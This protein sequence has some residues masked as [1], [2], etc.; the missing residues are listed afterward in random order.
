MKQTWAVLAAGAVLGSTLL[1]GCMERQGDLGNRNIRENSVRYDMLGN[2]VKVPRFDKDQMNVVNRMHGDRL[3]TNSL[4]G[5][6]QNYHLSMNGEI[7]QK[8]S[9]MKEVGKA[10]V[11]LT[12]NNAYVAITTNLTANQNNLKNNSTNHLRS[13]SRINGSYLPKGAAIPRGYQTQSLQDTGRFDST[14]SYDE[15]KPSTGRAMTPRH[16]AQYAPFAK[17][18]PHQSH[19]SHQLAAEPHISA[20]IKERI[21]EE[22]RKM[23][24]HIKQVYVSADPDFVS[25]MAS[26]WEDAKKGHP[27]QG[28]IVEFNALVE[29]VFP[30]KN[31]AM[32]TE[33]H[34]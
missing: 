19:Q 27:I 12:D 34:Q 20:A 5:L 3:H 24:P 17:I 6:H 18:D 22:V 4:V 30:A 31:G 15:L 2:Q 26:Y 21:T 14:K 25:R 11:M 28:F 32:N 33:N 1:T 16:E 8:L 7:A 10:F 13:L 9:A 29:R 23:A